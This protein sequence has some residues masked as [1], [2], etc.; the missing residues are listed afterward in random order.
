[1]SSG[2]T[3]MSAWFPLDK[4]MTILSVRDMR[5]FS[6]AVI[7]EAT[8]LSVILDSIPIKNLRR[9]QSPL[10]EV[11]LPEDNVFDS[12][13]SPSPVPANVYSPAV[14]DGIYVLLNPLRV[15]SHTLHF[16]SKSG[17]RRGRYVYA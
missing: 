5:N 6:A 16:H 4:A 7:D 12:P 1:M 13:C 2:A 10:F 8:D 15:G 17:F 9:V 3:E 11:T 14:D